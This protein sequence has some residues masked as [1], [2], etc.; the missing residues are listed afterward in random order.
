MQVKVEVKL[1]YFGTRRQIQNARQGHKC[2]NRQDQ[3]TDCRQDSNQGAGNVIKTGKVIT[4]IS[5]D[6]S[7]EQAKRILRKQSVI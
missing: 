4:M 2:D 7:G 1:K 3:Q 6:I 5:L